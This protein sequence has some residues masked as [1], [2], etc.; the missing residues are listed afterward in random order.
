MLSVSEHLQDPAHIAQTLNFANL[1]TNFAFFWWCWGL[2]CIVPG[3]GSTKQCML[4]WYRPWCF[5]CHCSAEDSKQH[6]SSRGDHST[7]TCQFAK[8]ICSWVIHF[9]FLSIF[10]NGDLFTN[11]DAK[12]GYYKDCE[13]YRCRTLWVLFLYVFS[14]L[15]YVINSAHCTCFHVRN[16]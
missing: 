12:V 3:D 5:W 8:W 1:R 13:H 11:I 6:H 7:T 2:M 4:S 10:M 15:K 9:S 16:S 14:L